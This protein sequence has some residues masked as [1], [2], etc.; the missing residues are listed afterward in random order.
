MSVTSDFWKAMNSSGSSSGG[1]KSSGSSNKS[2][3]SPSKGSTPT[4]KKK[5]KQTSISNDFWSTMREDDESVSEKYFKLRSGQSTE[6]DDFAP[7]RPIS[8]LRDKSD[9]KDEDDSLLDLFQKGAFEDGFD[10][11][12]IPKVILGTAADAGLSAVRGA[13]GL[14]E[15]IGDAIVYGAAEVGDLLGMDERADQLRRNAQ[16]SQVDRLTGGANEWLDQYSVLGRS[17]DAG[18][19][20]VGQVLGLTGATAAIA[21]TAPVTVPALIIS[22]GLMAL[23]GVGQGYGEAY[24][25]GA[26]DEEA[27]KH[28]LNTGASDALSEMLFGAMGKAA[29][30]TGLSK[31][32][33]NIDD[34]IAVMASKKFKSQAAKNLVE[35]GVKMSAEGLEEVI[36]GTLQA[37]SKYNTYMSEEDFSK[38]LK[39]ENLAEQFFAG[40]LTAGIMQ[41]GYVPGMREGSL[42]EANETGRDFITGQTQNEQAVIQKELENRIAKEEEQNGKKLTNKQKAD[43]EEKV[44][45]DME[46]GY[47][48]TDTI[49]EVLGGETYQ[50]YLNLKAESDEYN[51]LYETESGKLSE[52]QKDRLAELKEKNKANSYEEALKGA[53]KQLYDEVRNSVNGDRLVESYNEK[54]RVYQDFQADFDQFKGS[55]HEDAARKTLE[56][57]V[58]AGANNTNRIH[59]FVDFVAKESAN[60]GLT[61]DFKS[62]DD[63]KADF[64]ARQQKNIAE[65]ENLTERTAEQDA[66]LADLKD[67]L[68]K[69]ESGETIVN[70][71]ITEN[72]IVLNLG[73]K[74]TPVKPLNR[75]VGHEITHSLELNKHYKE[76][77]DSL[78]QY[79]K[80]KGIDVDAELKNRKL[81]YKGAKDADAKAELVA[82]LVGDFLFTDENYVKHLSTENR[83]VFQK[84]W[85]EI[86]HLCKMV[87]AGSQ[88]ARE[89]ER[90]RK[91]FEDAYREGSKKQDGTKNS[92]GYHAGDLGKAESY[93][94]QGGGRSTGHFGTGT[95]FVGNKAAIEGYNKRNGKPAPIESVEFDNYNLFKVHSDEKGYALHKSL[96]AIDGGITQEQL[97]AAIKGK[98]RASELRSEA[99]HLGEKYQITEWDD[100]LGF[101]TTTNFF[102]ASI[103]AMTEV[104]EANN[105]EFQTYDEYLEYV[106]ETELKQGDPDYYTYQDEY[107]DYLK[108]RLNEADEERNDGYTKIR[109][110]Q[111]ELRWMFGEKNVN[112]ALQAVIDYDTTMEQA[113]YDTMRV[114]DSRATV[115]MKALGYEGIDVRGTGLDNTTYGSVIYDLK[116]EDAKRKAEI[117]T[118]RYSLSSMANTFFGDENMSSAEFMKKDYREAQ[119]YKDY[120][121][122]CLN[123]YSQT[124]KDFDADVARKEIEDSI[125]G[126]VKVAI[127]AKAAGY[128]ILDDQTK[129]DTK[130]SKQRLLFSSLEPN[131]DYITSHDISTICDKRKNFAE[132]YDDI[133]KAEEAK[134]VPQNK[135]FF[136][137]VDNYFYL[138]KLM[139]DKGLTQPCR[140]C[141]V[142]SMRKN[143]APMANAFL[144][145]VSEQNPNNTANDQL[146]HQKGKNKGELKTN[147]AS[148]RE[149]VQAQLAEYGMSVNDLTVETLTTEDGLARL[150]IQ[151]PLIYEAFNS[152]Y[153]QSK[154][155]MP[156]S[157]TPFRFGELTALMTDEKGRIKKSLVDKINSTG[158]FRLQSYSDFQIQNYTDVLQVLFEAGTL[159]LNGHAYTKVPAFLDATEGTNLKRNISI[160]MYKDGYEWKLDRNDSFPYTLEEIY[161]I[162]KADKSGNTGIIAVSQNAD[163]SAWIMANDLVGYGIPFHKSGLKMGT[164]RDT[165]VREGGREIKGYTGTKDHT[166]QQTEV[167]KETTSEHKKETKVKKGIN[168][169]SFWDFD[170]KSNLSKNE[171]IEKNVKNYID[172][173]DDAGYLPKFRE[174]VMNNGK[175]LADVLKYSKELGYAAKDATIDDISFEYKG[176]RIPYGYYKFLGD[177]GMFNPDGQAAPQSTLS[178]KDYDFDKAAKFFYNSENLRRN[179]ILQQFSNG[180]ERQKYRDSNLTA[181]QL[182]DIVKQKRREV[183]EGV[184]SRHSLSNGNGQFAPASDFDVYGSDFLKKQDADDAAPVVE[185]STATAEPAPVAQVEEPEDEAPLPE[186]MQAVL[187]DDGGDPQADRDAM[188]ARMAA[189]EE[190]LNEMVTSGVEMDEAFQAKW[191]QLGDEWEALDARVKELEQSEA[192]RTE[193]LTDEDAPPRMPTAPTEEQ[194]SDVCNELRS[195]LPVEDSDMVDLGDIVERYASGDIQ[196]RDDLIAE[197]Q[198]DYGEYAETEQDELLKEIKKQIRTRG[199]RV[200]DTIKHGIPDYAKWMRSNFGKLRISKNGTDV[201]VLWKELQEEYPNYFPENIYVPE[202]Q[203]LHIA[204]LVNQDVT[205]TIWHPVGMKDIEAAADAIINAARDFDGFT[206]T[207]ALGT[208]EVP[209]QQIYIHP[210][211]TYDAV[212]TD[213][214]APTVDTLG[215]VEVPGQQTFVK[216]DATYDAAPTDDIAPTFDTTGKKGVPDGQQAFMP[217]AGTDVKQTRKEYHQSIIDNIKARFKARGFDFDTVLKK[218]K[219]L[220]TWSTV[221]NTPQ[222]VMEK[223]LG[224]KEGGILADITVNKVA[225]NES[226]GIKWINKNVELLKQI[227]KDYNIKPGSKKSAAAQM[228]AEGFYVD[229]DNNIVQYGDREL[230]IDFPDP[231]VRANIKGLARD[232]RIRKMYD[233]TLASINES[234]T[235][236]LYP[237]IPRL[238]NYFLHFRAMNDT[239]STLGLPFNPND[240]RAKDLPTDLN[241]V[242][243]DLKPGQP[244]F[245]SAMHRTGKRTSFDMLGGIERYLNSAKNQI[246]H[247]DDIQ[248]LRALRNHIAE[249]YGQATG[250]EDLDSLTDAEAEERIKQVYGSHLSTFAKFLNEEANVLA[251]KTALIDR[252]IEGIIG[253]RGITFLNTLNGQVGSNMVGYNIS[254]SLTNFLPVAQTFAKTNKADFVKAFAQTAMNKFSGVIGGKLDTFSD[255]SPV[256]IRRKGQDNFYQTPWQRVK[257]PGYVL[258]GAVDDISTELIARTKYNEFIRKGMDSQKAHFET[259]KWVSRLMGD[260]SLGQQPQ[261]YNSKMLGLVTKFQLEVRNQ[262]DAQFYDTIQETKV[263]NEQIQNGLL[264]NA[265]TAAK[266]TSTFVQLA[267]AQHLFGKAFESV[268]GYNPAFDIIEVLMT[269]FGFDDEEDS[270]DTVLDN[271]EQG[272]LELLEDMPYASTFLDGGRIPIS[273]AMPIDELVKGKDQYGNEKSRWETVGEVAPYYLMPAGYGQLKKS[274]AGLKMFSDEHP[275]AGSYTDAGNLRFPVEDTLGNRAK[276]AVFGQ[277]ASETARKYF[278]GEQRTLNHDQTEIF[279]ELDMPIEEYWE[280]RDNLNKFYDVKDKLKEAADAD[281]ATEADILK[282][283]YITAVNSDLYDLYDKQKELAKGNSLTKKSQIQ[284]IQNQMANLIADSQRDIDNIYVNGY[285]ATIG[286]KRFDYSDYNGKWYEISGEYLEKE[287]KAIERYGVTPDYYWN[288]TD[289]FY[290]ADYYFKYNPELEDVS[291]NVFDGEWFAGY[292]A[293]VSQ[294]KGDDFNNDGKTDS[295][296]K[297]KKVFAYI[298]GLDVSDHEKYIL[299]RMSYT[300]ERTH[301]YDIVEYVS[302]RSDLSYDQKMAVLEGLGYTLDD[303]GYVLDKGKYIER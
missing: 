253:R 129:R 97:N 230:A 121:D 228:Y 164:V 186:D 261:L 269:A 28:A 103:R 214:I 255:D 183:A 4:T 64:I 102:E 258:M 127:A 244:Y 191:H 146:Y 123:N 292:A 14:G 267:V 223:A 265:K 136:S 104:A 66:E 68:A 236:N 23:S 82:D 285:Y 176:Y 84:L 126:I 48:S 147:N 224:Y 208:N 162:V 203:L 148:T 273:E 277:Y 85:D 63:I 138:H 31:G 226:E 61:F 5:K 3:G 270:E 141:Y 251:G 188:T 202:D 217:N 46:R 177:F 160:F 211:A 247:I 212:P 264:R 206:T 77:Q 178:L 93:F 266:V 225:Q 165:I 288:N 53:K 193:S 21:A 133:V 47:I 106:G 293:H 301:S 268:A 213:D 130:D 86:K 286:D 91:A 154:P 171:L 263:S 89:L 83:N 51:T 189:I 10:W 173:C 132:I 44:I 275:I 94:Q 227:S 13:A 167:W 39:D 201:D 112:R 37:V 99:F 174:Y 43:L 243:A 262:L 87:T 197:I 207:T 65:L 278:D 57:A 179:E 79:A 250:L 281:N 198:R 144:R 187:P 205:T 195:Y 257:N 192:D 26:T 163:M 109:E 220:S 295:G 300:S 54:A 221:D 74:N 81:M 134:G 122:Q 237:E 90:V 282:G 92:L 11:S 24:Q 35:A 152:F 9:D 290:H 135:R 233:D 291:K 168:I 287:Q 124:R 38:I 222:R 101:E 45:K 56:N 259:D 280:Y 231:K 234:R 88:E 100:E 218:A 139:A 283:K 95:Y 298:D 111:W 62:N 116:G 157:A 260:R 145:L 276:A 209:G 69:V 16:V 158:G 70:G 159:G 49:E 151:A 199:I 73:D 274:V 128:D 156:K 71:D 98:F 17:V 58:K 72:G 296:S 114:A 216:P 181:E 59:D 242:T 229:K 131:S 125:E 140:Q 279:A 175:V 96:H 297:K 32:L 110:A 40:A 29:K 22:G 142:E 210:A 25:G 185:E 42:R 6:D 119:G 113:D 299:K 1:S 7:I 137:N 67:L 15:G 75:V 240:I 117:G 190:E 232:P 107:Y 238:D 184:V 249:T 204:D 150:K 27:R 246:Y 34:V 235:R 219:N 60:T 20:G 289:Q 302:N 143:L 215:S 41:S 245:A 182:S 18:L 170:N 272:F 153:G 76:L 271:L 256:V 248:T 55:K 33:T 149:W 108:E 8:P 239:F 294:I 120:V 241:G 50:N 180:E 284:S 172:A 30:V 118:A 52:K 115:F 200:S 303:E 194:I 36:S 12:D 196:T 169:Y 161:D 105:V 254:S 80:T 252:G 2:S 19:Q 78:F 155:K 166:K